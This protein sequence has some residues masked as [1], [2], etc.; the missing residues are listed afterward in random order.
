MELRHLRYFV[1]AAELLHFT[2]A[3]ESLYVSQPTLSSH[4]QQLEEELG[5]PL[6][7]RLGRRV[8]L[9]E[10]GQLLLDHA[11]NAIREVELGKER[12]AE[13]LGL[14]RGTLRVGTTQ[15]FSH[16][17]V[18]ISLAAYIAAY[19][20][21]H[22]LV[23]WGTSPE[24][25][26]SVLAGTVDLGLAFLPPDSDEIEYEVLLSDE[27]VLVVS[28]KHPLA[29]RE[30]VS[31]SELGGLPLVLLSTGLSTRRLVDTRFAKENISPNILL[32]TNDIPAVLTIAETG[33]AG[34]FVSRRL[35]VS[36]PDLHPLSLS[37]SLVRSAGILRRKGI[38]LSAAARA[39]LEVI[40]V[41]CQNIELRGGS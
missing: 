7:D 33:S 23:Q 22:V 39:F 1:R 19:P 28:N 26:R 34:T 36:H 4:I 10:A 21:I 29:A 3:A 41:H 35:V 14:L 20:D 31:V 12:I 15:V 27:V 38:H 30:A 32:E 2:R 17:L 13:L 24:V 9:T 18:P 37:P 6:F 8:R 5:S 16:Y 11:R 40:K 25:E